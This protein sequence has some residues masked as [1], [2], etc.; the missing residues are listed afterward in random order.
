MRDVPPLCFLFQLMPNYCDT[1]RPIKIVEHLQHRQATC[2]IRKRKCYGPS[3]PNQRQI[4]TY[5]ISRPCGVNKNAKTFH[6]D[7]DFDFDFCF[8]FL[9][10]VSIFVFA[11]V[12]LSFLLLFLLLLLFSFYFCFCFSFNFCFFKFFF[13]IF[14]FKFYYGASRPPYKCVSIELL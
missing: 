13:L 9:F 2:K 7:F 3:K 1:S 11:F 14:I 4:T 6:F 8:L 10:F 12:F 5:G